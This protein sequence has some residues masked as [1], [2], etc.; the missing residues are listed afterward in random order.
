MALSRKGKVNVRCRQQDLI[1]CILGVFVAME[2]IVVLNRN[3]LLFLIEVKT[4][5]KILSTLG[6]EHSNTVMLIFMK[7]RTR[8]IQTFLI[9]FLNQDYNREYVENGVD[10]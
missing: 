8:I 2:Y 9:S 4:R 7:N 6:K 10:F 5:E 1:S 3:R